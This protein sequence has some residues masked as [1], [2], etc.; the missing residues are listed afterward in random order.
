MQKVSRSY[1]PCFYLLTG[2]PVRIKRLQTELAESNK[3][4]P[5]RVT[6]HLAALFFAIFN[7]F[8]H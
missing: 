4:L 5:A 8:R 7:S 6:L 1:S 3:I 2:Y